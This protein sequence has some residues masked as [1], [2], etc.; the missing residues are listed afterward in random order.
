MYKPAYNTRKVAGSSQGFKH[1]PK[2]IAK[3]KKKYM[4]KNYI[5]DSVLKLVKNKK[6]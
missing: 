4:L 6:L 5:L 3:L 1:S 2:T